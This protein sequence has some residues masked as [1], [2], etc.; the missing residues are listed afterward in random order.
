MLLN[1]VLNAALVLLASAQASASTTLR[2]A[3][4][5]AS[6]AGCAEDVLSH[7]DCQEQI[8]SEFT[9]LPDGY[10][11]IY[12]D[13]CASTCG[14]DFDQPA[15]REEIGLD[16]AYYESGDFLCV[17]GDDFED[18]FHFNC[19]LYEGARWCAVGADG[20]ATEGPAWCDWFNPPEGGCDIARDAR[21]PRHPGYAN[22]EGRWAKSCCCNSDLA[23]TYPYEGEEGE[24][25]DRPDADGRPWTD[26]NGYSCRAY[27]FGSFCTLDGEAGQGW[28]VEEYGE[29]RTYVHKGMSPLTACCTCGGGD[30]GGPF[31]T[32]FPTVEATTYVPTSS[33]PTT[34]SPTT[35]VPTSFSLSAGEEAVIA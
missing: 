26:G 18:A 33:P 34:V 15:A 35:D 14:C 12:A 3:L 28:S 13:V 31:K 6:E 21:W 22:E 32:L 4:G 1:F 23:E 9:G 5:V 17:D 25:V 29:V 8:D 19:T 16:D 11:Y 20:F 10:C 24:C 2:A 7:R 27:H 30:D